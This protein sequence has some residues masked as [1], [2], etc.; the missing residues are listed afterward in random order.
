MYENGLND[1]KTI[2]DGFLFYVE[3]S[4]TQRE[5]EKIFDWFEEIGARLEFSNIG[6]D[7]YKYDISRFDNTDINFIKIIYILT[8]KA[9]KYDKHKIKK[10]VNYIEKYYDINKKHGIYKRTFIHYFIILGK[11]N[12]TK[13]YLLFEI[14]NK[15]SKLYYFNNDI[16]Y[17]EKDV[18][19]NTYLHLYIDEFDAWLCV[20]PYIYDYKLL[21]MKNKDGDNPLM[22]LKKLLETRRD[23]YGTKMNLMLKKDYD[24]MSETLENLGY[25]INNDVNNFL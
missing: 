22:I 17:L 3:E 25:N 11:L 23:E 21:T 20:V 2:N 9:N 5:F 8:S 7:T 24:N 19:G 14:L 12:Y 18:N 16:N 6:N 10:I 1:D 4:T 15:D 13:K